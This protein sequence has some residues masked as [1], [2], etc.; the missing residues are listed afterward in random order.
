MLELCWEKGPKGRDTAFVTPPAKGSNK[1]KVK[2]M[3]KSMVK[4]VCTVLKKSSCQSKVK[5]MNKLQLG[6]SSV[7]TKLILLS[8]QYK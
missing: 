3:T 4:A 7:A 5:K 6:I 8:K 1:S 2:N